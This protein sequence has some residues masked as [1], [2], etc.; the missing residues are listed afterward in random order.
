VAMPPYSLPLDD[1]LEIR[2]GV[3]GML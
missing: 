2:S 3:S 1:A